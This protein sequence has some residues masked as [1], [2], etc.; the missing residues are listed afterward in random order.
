MTETRE[1]LRCDCCGKEIMAMIIGN[2]CVI[3]KRCHG[4]EHYCTLTVD[5]LRE[6]IEN[7]SVSVSVN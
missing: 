4:K 2:R 6:L 7:K 3:M 1:P 5:M